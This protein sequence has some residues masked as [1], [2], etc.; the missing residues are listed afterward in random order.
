MNKYHRLLKDLKEHGVGKMK[1]FGHSMMPIIKTGSTLT[2]ETAD[3]YEVGDVVFSKVKGRFIDA[4]KITKKDPS[5]RY[6]ISNN[7]GWDN[8]WTRQIYGKVTKIEN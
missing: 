8:G 3:D 7:K 4:H 2:F 5:G 1:V 6:L